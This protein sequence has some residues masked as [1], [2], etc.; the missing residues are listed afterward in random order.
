M[1]LH[2]TI[3]KFMILILLVSISLALLMRPS[4]LGASILFSLIILLNLVALLV[5]LSKK[6]KKLKGFVG[7]SISYIIITGYYYPTFPK[8]IWL[9]LVDEIH[10]IT[11]KSTSTETERESYEYQ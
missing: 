3:A 4:E 9:H 2:F 5:V 1:R 8:P 6:T 11:Y 10:I 7:F